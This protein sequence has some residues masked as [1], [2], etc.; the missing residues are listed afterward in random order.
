[1]DLQLWLYYLLAILVLTASPGPSILLCV[2]KSVTIGFRSA[3]YSALGIISAI[4]LILTLSFTGLGLIISQSEW[5]FGLIKWTGAAYL[6]YLGIKALRSNQAS[7]KT[8][9]LESSEGLKPWSH[10]WTGFIVGASNPKAIVFFTALFPQFIDP[11]APLL[12]QYL[13]L[14]ATFLVLELFWLLAYAY[15]GKRSSH[16]LMA[17]GRAKWFNR[18]SGSVFVSAGALLST[19]SRAAN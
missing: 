7:L 6:V 8:T 9:Q 16:W 15:L 18:V 17:E 13:V 4:Y 2:S 19:T 14:A 11:N 12:A 5:I 3:W 10:Y 1:M